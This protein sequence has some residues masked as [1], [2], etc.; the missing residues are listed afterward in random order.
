MRLLLPLLLLLPLACG[1]GAERRSGGS[2]RNVS[3]GTIDCATGAAGTLVPACTME[4]R[5]SDLM[6]V[7]PS[8]FRR[9]RIVPG[10]GVAAADGAA[11]AHARPVSGGRVEVDIGG[12]R[13]RLDRSVLR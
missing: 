1:R 9:L 12:D 11:A 5:G 7:S 13:F 3:A 10:G 8:G 4:R 2:A 6:I